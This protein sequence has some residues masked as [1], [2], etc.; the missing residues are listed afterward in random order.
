MFSLAQVQDVP[1]WCN[2]GYWI[3]RLPTSNHAI[4]GPERSQVESRLDSG[5]RLQKRWAGKFPQAARST[6]MSVS[7]ARI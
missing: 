1:Y 4:S 3:S 5:I 7:P 2:G 6:V